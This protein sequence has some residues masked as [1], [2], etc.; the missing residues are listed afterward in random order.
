MSE[1][2]QKNELYEERFAETSRTEKNL[3]E[4]VKLTNEKRD[5]LQNQV[6]TL[7]S[8][9]KTLQDENKELQL[10]KTNSKRKMI[11]LEKENANMKKIIE[12]MNTPPQI[13]Q[14][15]KDGA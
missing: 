13:E 5:E 9:V 4:D 6:D 8:T 15:K 10:F 11:T 3:L 2:L 7:E 14:G 12:Y 1:Q